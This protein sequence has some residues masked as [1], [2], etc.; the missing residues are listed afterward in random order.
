MF[1]NKD[2]NK[3]VQAIEGKKA[4]YTALVLAIIYIPILINSFTIIYDRFVIQE[5]LTNFK[6]ITLVGVVSFLTA[7]VLMFILFIINK[8]YY[9][10][11]K[12]ELRNAFIFSFLIY[13]MSQLLHLSKTNFVIADNTFYT[14]T[15]IFIHGVVFYLFLFDYD[16]SKLGTYNSTIEEFVFYETERKFVFKNDLREEKL[17]T[18]PDPIGDLTLLVKKQTEQLSYS[19]DHSSVGKYFTY[20]LQKYNYK[21]SVHVLIYFSSTGK[22]LDEILSINHTYDIDSYESKLEELNNAVNN[23]L[24]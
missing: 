21:D 7:I 13:S 11:D 17:N 14:F 23:Y 19:D 6:Y 8:K 4:R 20:Y 5:Q 1:K 2:I 10:R 12:R 16:V 9:I 18:S 15:F 22:K 3:K 24:N